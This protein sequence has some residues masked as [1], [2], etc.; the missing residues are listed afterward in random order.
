ML[1]LV[2]RAFG[3]WRGGDPGVKTRQSPNIVMRI[4]EDKREWFRQRAAQKGITQREL[5]ENMI[6]F[7]RD[8]VEKKS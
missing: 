5:M 3:C 1:Q 6:Q 8:E 2:S 4:D 7:I